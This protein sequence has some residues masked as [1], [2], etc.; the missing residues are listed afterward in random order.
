MENQ[1][2]ARRRRDPRQHNLVHTGGQRFHDPVGQ[3]PVRPDQCICRQ[4]RAAEGPICKTVAVAGK[5]PELVAMPDPEGGELDIRHAPGHLNR[6]APG[7][8]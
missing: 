4:G 8:R 3:R 6:V 7:R 2:A 5:A 1:R